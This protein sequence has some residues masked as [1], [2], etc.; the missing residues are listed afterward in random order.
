MY[1]FI[2]QEPVRLPVGAHHAFIDYK[3][4][5]KIV[6]RIIV[7]LGLSLLGIDEGVLAPEL[8]G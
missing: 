8:G 3:K 5:F 4:G 6:L 1:A 7:E 2:A